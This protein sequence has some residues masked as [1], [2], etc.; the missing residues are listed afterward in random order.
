MSCLGIR[1]LSFRIGFNVRHVWVHFEGSLGLH[2][3]STMLL[4]HRSTKGPWA[5]GPQAEGI[6]PFGGNFPALGRHQPSKID[7]IFD[8]RTMDYRTRGRQDDWM[9][10][11]W[12]DAWRLELDPRSLLTP[13]GGRRIFKFLQTYMLSK[14]KSEGA[15]ANPGEFANNRLK[16]PGVFKVWKILK[17]FSILWEYSNILPGSFKLQHI[18]FNRST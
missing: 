9:V 11:T 3:W 15:I 16:L 13:K 6:W 17:L 2:K 1:V 4:K 7:R 8:T 5:E 18:S 14:N 10:W 12:L